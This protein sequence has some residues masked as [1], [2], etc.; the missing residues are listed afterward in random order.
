MSTEWNIKLYTS[1]N[2]KKKHLKANFGF[3]CYLVLPLEGDK[4]VLT[5]KVP[6]IKIGSSLLLRHL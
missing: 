5:Q 6:S 2:S 3:V 1:K 4:V